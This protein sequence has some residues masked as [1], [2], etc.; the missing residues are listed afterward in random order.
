MSI[1]EDSD[2]SRFGFLPTNDSQYEALVSRFINRS[3][4]VIIW[5]ISLDFL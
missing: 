1:V 4:I 3:G 2:D 5:G